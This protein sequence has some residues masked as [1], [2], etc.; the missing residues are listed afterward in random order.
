M[1][2]SPALSSALGL[3]RRA[4]LGASVS[5]ALVGVCGPATRA[6][7]ADESGFETRALTI[8]GKHAKRVE[9]LVP[10]HA[11]GPVELLVAL[12]GLGESFDEEAGARAWLDRY[13]LA[14]SYARLLSP[15]IARTQKRAD[16]T[17]E[18]LAKV[19]ASLAAAPFGGLAVAC[20]FTPNFR[21]VADRTRAIRDYGDWIVGEVLPAVRR[22]LGDRAPAEGRRAVHAIDGCSMG[23]PYAIEIATRHARVFGKLGVVQGAFGAHRAKPFAAALKRA[24]EDAGAPAIQILSS[25]GDTFVDAAKAFSEALSDEGLS[26]QLTVLPGPHDQPWLREAG[27]IEMLLF[28]E[29]GQL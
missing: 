4:L 23:G 7:A 15:P 19:N 17:D 21:D 1:F 3:S 20:P 9:L 6:S 11:R 24:S 14:T 2:R 12:H 8:P 16:W 22:E 13:G 25:S 18:R 28:H 27:T 29:R 26:H 5:S 10:K